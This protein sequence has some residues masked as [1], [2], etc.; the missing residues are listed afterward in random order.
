LGE[1]FVP[2]E[3]KSQVFLGAKVSL[4]QSAKKEKHPLK[5]FHT[6]KDRVRKMF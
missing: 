2:A 5:D 6:T 3:E 4:N 1:G